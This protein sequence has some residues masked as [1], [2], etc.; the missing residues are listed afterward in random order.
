[1]VGVRPDAWATNAKPILLSIRN[2]MDTFFEWLAF[3]K[4]Q[5]TGEQSGNALERCVRNAC[6]DSRTVSELWSIAVFSDGVFQPMMIAINESDKSKSMISMRSVARTIGHH[7][8]RWSCG[9]AIDALRIGWLMNGTGAASKVTLSK[10]ATICAAAPYLDDRMLSSLRCVSRATLWTLLKRTNTT[11][12]QLS[13]L[14]TH[15]LVTFERFIEEYLPNGALHAPSAAVRAIAAVAPPN[16]DAVERLFGV[17]DHFNSKVAV[18]MTASNKEGRI[19]SRVNHTIEWWMAQAPETREQVL[20]VTRTYA[21]KSKAVIAQRCQRDDELRRLR[22]RTKQETSQRKSTKRAIKDQRNAALALWTS[23]AE[24]TRSLQ[25]ISGKTARIQ[26][27]KQQLSVYKKR[28]S[29]KD[30]RLSK[31]GKPLTEDELKEQLLTVIA[32]FGTAAATAQQQQQPT[33]T[34]TPTPND[35]A[36]ASASASASTTTNGSAQRTTKGRQSSA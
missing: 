6:R 28:H 3:E 33:P 30:V 15:V 2:G 24:L 12:Q 7:L 16:N 26:S 22:S 1:V 10:D 5:G 13:R 23:E 14:A 31:A 35:N 9:N 8:R 25:S 27:L 21:A 29:A 4:N 36:P 17:Y 20:Q 34:P 11:T 32:Q 18:N 19:M